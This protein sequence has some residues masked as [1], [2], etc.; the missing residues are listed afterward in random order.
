MKYRKKPLVI[1]ALQLRWDTWSAMCDF[2]DVGNLA[3]GKP[4]GFSP[5]GDS[6]L[7][8]LRIPTLEGVMIAVENDWIIK[9]IKGELYPC[10][11]DIFTATYEEVP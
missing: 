4:Q 6:T 3:D 10:K 8:G 11:P 5:D 7:I 2:A 9:G 1:E